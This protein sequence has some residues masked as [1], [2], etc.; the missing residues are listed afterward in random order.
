[1]RAN[2]GV[3]GCFLR[4]LSSIR[5][6][7]ILY[8]GGSRALL[9]NSVPVASPGRPEISRTTETDTRYASELDRLFC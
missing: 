3:R 1:M 2:A 4:L 7:E 5:V 9:P 8:S 6:V